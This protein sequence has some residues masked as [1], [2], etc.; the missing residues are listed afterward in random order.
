VSLPASGGEGTRMDGRVHP[1]ERARNVV[2]GNQPKL[3]RGLRQ[4]G[5]VARDR[6]GPLPC[7]GHAMLPAHRAH[8]TRPCQP[9]GTWY[10]RIAPSARKGG[11][12][13]GQ[14]IA[15]RVW[16]WEKANAV[17]S[18][19]GY[20]LRQWSWQ[21][22]STRTR[23]DFPAGSRYEKHGG[24]GREG[25]AQVGGFVHWCSLPRQGIDC[26]RVSYSQQVV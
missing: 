19:G 15:M 10:A 12:S 20:G 17:L 13:S 16:G 26:D 24:I 6:D 8:L 2:Q 1:C 3:L 11:K 22:H 5:T 18:W 25:G 21:H 14:P 9:W 7:H 4:K 23:A